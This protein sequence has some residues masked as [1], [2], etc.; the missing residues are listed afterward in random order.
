[1]KLSISLDPTSISQAISQL[2]EYQRSF[3]SKLDELCR[4]LAEIGLETAVAAVPVDTG[5]LKSSIFMERRG[6]AEYVVVADN[7]HA[8]F[9][10]FGTGV[11]GQGTYDG[12]LPSS[13][14]YDQRR[15]PTAHDPLDPTAW[16][17]RNPNTGIVHKTRGHAAQP[18]ML[19]AS[20]A[21]RQSVMAIA[22]EVFA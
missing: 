10:E 15:T 16:Y 7:D 11:V 6:N 14:G 17:Y 8:A 19:P 2:Q 18:Y 22:K 13:W 20:E 4:R 3:E 12:E 1:M 5:D 21:M 9:V